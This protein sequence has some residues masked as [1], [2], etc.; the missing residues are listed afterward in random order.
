MKGRNHGE[1]TG[2]SRVWRAESALFAGLRHP[3]GRAECEGGGG[4]QTSWGRKKN[5]FLMGIGRAVLSSELKK[6]WKLSEERTRW[7]LLSLATGP[8]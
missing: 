8:R 2:R 1:M 5:L 3:E 4:L 7:P 6:C